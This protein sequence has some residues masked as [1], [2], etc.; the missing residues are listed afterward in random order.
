MV[1]TIYFY[2]ENKKYLLT[3]FMKNG[4]IYVEIYLLIRN[5]SFDVMCSS[6]HDTI[7]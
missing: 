6:I 3:N 7:N 5:T 2:V 4:K 1:S